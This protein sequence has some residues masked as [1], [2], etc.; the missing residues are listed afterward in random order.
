MGT[1]VQWNALSGTADRLS[2][3]S[4]ALTAPS[5]Q[6][7][8]VIA[9]R[10]LANNP[11]YFRLRDA[12]VGALYTARRYDTP[13]LNITHLTLGQQVGGI[14]VFQAEM[15][16][17]VDFQGRIVAANGT[18]VPQLSRTVT[19]VAPKLTQGQALLLAAGYA[20]M[21]NPALAG[22][23]GPASGVRQAVRFGKG[24]QFLREP[25][26][27]LV[28]LHTAA[29]QTTLAW[30]TTLVQRNVSDVYHVLVDAV[31]G[32]AALAQQP[33]RAMLQPR[34]ID[35]EAP[36]DGTPFNPASRSRPCSRE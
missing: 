28:Y 3:P 7:S 26:V 32:P 25:E 23:L 13:G 29:G 34:C 20:G 14:P 17:H 36:Q 16:F 35:H 6:D 9:R 19:A 8:E 1:Q 24:S 33:I 12:E 15:G 11:G 21:K 2:H 5:A 30:E 22:P 31:T 27:Q 18:L 10:F 4:G